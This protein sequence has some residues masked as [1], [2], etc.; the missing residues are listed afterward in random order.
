MQEDDDAFYWQ[1]KDGK[2]MNNIEVLEALLKQNP[3][4]P[5]PAVVA[6]AS[7]RYL[8]GSKPPT[9][10]PKMRK[11]KNVTGRNFDDVVQVRACVCACVCACV[12]G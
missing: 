8:A 11:L 6:Q 1:K 10:K 4:L 3:V 12:R 2:L 5:Q 9:K 7:G